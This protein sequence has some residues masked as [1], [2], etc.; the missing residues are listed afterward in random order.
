[1][2]I[3][4][5]SQPPPPLSVYVQNSSTPLTFDV[6]FQTNPHSILNE[7]LIICFFVALYSCVCGCPKIS[8]NVFFIYNYSQFYY[9]FCNQLVL[10]V[11]LENV[12]KL[13]KINYTVRVNKLLW[14]LPNADILLS[15]TS[16]RRTKNFVPDEFLKN[17]L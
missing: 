15:G 2:K 14:N 17:L 6:Q 7:S 1:M 10:F 5:F 8:R 13:L 12:N 4:Q 9:W 11:Q 3:V 16:L